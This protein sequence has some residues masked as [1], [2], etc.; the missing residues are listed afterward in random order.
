MTGS[1]GNENV[2]VRLWARVD[3]HCGISPLLL[4]LAPVTLFIVGLF[5]CGTMDGLAA[6]GTIFNPFISQES[7][8]EISVSPS[9]YLINTI[10]NHFPLLF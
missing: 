9:F 8:Q 4:T 5:Y 7:T 1:G 2:E 10:T 6:F 3:S